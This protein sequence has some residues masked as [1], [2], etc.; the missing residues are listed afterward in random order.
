M[1]GIYWMRLKAWRLLAIG[2][3]IAVY[4]LLLV[5]DARFIFSS[6]SLSLWI[7]FGFSAFVALVFLAVGV[8]VWLYARDR[9]VASLLFGSFSVIMIPFAVR[10]ADLFQAHLFGAISGVCS[11]LGLTLCALLLLR[12]PRNYF[13]RWSSARTLTLRLKQV[14]VW[15]YVI[16]LVLLCGFAL[17]FSLVHYLWPRGPIWLNVLDLIYAIVVLAGI[18]T[19]IVISYVCSESLRERQQIR[20]FVWGVALAFTPV[21]ILSILPEALNLPGIRAGWSTLTIV[22]LPLSLGYS[23]L[24]YQILVFDAY[25]R[26]AVAWIV[27]VVGLV[28]LGCVLIALCNKVFMGML[29]SFAFGL[30]S[31]TAITAPVVWWLAKVVTERVFFSEV[32]HYRRLIA[33]PTLLSDEILDLDEI[34]RLLTL[35]AIHTFETSHVCL[36]VLDESCGCY[37]V[38][39]ALKDDPG[40][41]ARRLLARVLIEKLRPQT[42]GEVD[43]LET[44]WPAVEHIASARRPSLLYELLREKIGASFGLRRYVVTTMP[45]GSEAML[46]APIR[47]QGKMI[48]LLV[49][50]E[51]DDL[52]QYAGPDFEAVQMLLGRFSP[53]LETARLYGRANQHAALLNSLYSVS[54]LPGSAF[55]SIEEIAAVYAAVAS[56]ATMSRAEMWLFDEAQG[57]LRLVISSGSGPHIADEAYLRPAQWYD[58]APWF[59]AGESS[60]EGQSSIAYMPSCLSLVPHFPFAWLPLQRGEQ[61]LGILVL[62][63][64]R[65]HC[66][67]REEMRVLQ[68]FASQCAASLEN[69]RITIELREA[70]ERQKELDRLKDQFIMTASHELRTPLTAIQGYIELLSEYNSTL[71]VEARGNFIA[72]A[73]RGCDELAL[74]VGNIMDASRVRIDAENIKLIPVLLRESIMYV[75]EILEAICKREKRRISLSVSP[76]LCVMADDMRLRQVLLNLV[77]NALKY[78]PPETDIEIAVIEDDTWVIVSVRDYGAGVPP[79]DQPRL[80]ERF[81]RLDRDM[82]SPVRGAGLGLYICKQLV[83]AMGGQIWIES[84]G[85]GGEGSTFAF[86]LKRTPSNLQ[87]S[88][89]KRQ[90]SDLTI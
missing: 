36:F 80:F 59:Y 75:L 12:F 24:R 2:T 90:E 26:R 52:Q 54:T 31:L 47:V 37:Y 55:Q 43:W 46:L 22:C 89:Q 65:P 13:T 61:R 15:M 30:A 7:S 51:R 45:L 77:S 39:P 27:G 53:V 62:T 86:T 73:H 25:I 8:L 16:A 87:V 64:W 9:W 84:S 1:R 57:L 76:E 17:S 44:Q 83:G 88:D 3:V 19:T 21:L 85:V 32:L 68:M 35:A 78:S 42:C 4:T 72:K 81:V 5:V 18:V 66:F 29:A 60:Q 49:L 38:Y 74:L 40:D 23:I 71:S 63:Y 34:S 6:P 28:M 50:G 20:L 69:A 79:S 10:T 70:C 41:E 48:G 56:E 14:A 33:E 82:N 11:S 67:M 58:W